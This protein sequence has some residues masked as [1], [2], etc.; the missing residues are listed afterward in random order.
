MSFFGANTSV[1]ILLSA[2]NSTEYR[3]GGLNDLMFCPSCLGEPEGEDK[4][5][6]VLD[7]CGDEDG[8]V[9]A[10]P[11][12]GVNTSYV[13]KR[14]GCCATRHSTFEIK[15]RDEQTWLTVVVDTR[16]CRLC[17]RN[18]FIPYGGSSVS[19]EDAFS[20][21]FTLGLQC[22]LYMIPSPTA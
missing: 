16:D 14:K 20:F 17:L 9:L 12:R 21:R 7:K 13:K 6:L 3:F 5:H 2:V 18:L 19:S 15:E 22:R 4:G 8:T 11:I 10:G 1:S